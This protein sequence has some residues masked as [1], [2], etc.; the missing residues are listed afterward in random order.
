MNDVAPEQIDA[1][2]GPRTLVICID[3]TS[4][5]AA[6]RPT[7]VFR[8]FEALEQSE[9][10]ITYY[11]G[12]VGT[13]LNDSIL[14]APIRAINNKIDLAAGISIRRNFESAYRFLAENY[15]PAAPGREADRIIMFGFSRG[16]YACRVLAGAIKLFGIPQRHKTNLVP[17][18]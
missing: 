6:H 8:L 9:Q 1:A 10:Q 7:H 16:A 13:L 11:D 4:D 14:L 12:G 3:G 18:F 2:A 17:F 15:R 5:F